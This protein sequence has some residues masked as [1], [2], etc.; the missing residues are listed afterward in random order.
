MRRP[1]NR[2]LKLIILSTTLLLWSSIEGE[3]QDKKWYNRLSEWV[4][5]EGWNFD[6]HLNTSH[7][8]YFFQFGGKGVE[9]LYLSPI[10]HKGW[11][12]KATFITDYAQPSHRNWHLYQELIISGSV[13]KNAGNGAKIY[14]LGIAYGLGPSWRVLNW[15]N[16]TLDLAP[17]ME[18]KLG[19]YYKPANTNNIANG[20]VSIGLDAWTR[21]RYQIP[22]SV[23]PIAISYTLQAPLIQGA[24]LPEYGQS[25]YDFISGENGSKIKLRAGHPLN[26]QGISQRLL[27]DLPLRNITITLGA[28]HTHF[29]Q[30]INHLK[31][32]EGSWSVVAGVSLDIFRLSGNKAIKSLELNSSL[33]NK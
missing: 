32:T 30:D 4:A 25:Y 3:A 12:G 9:D 28:E 11:E 18:L 10:A 2:L 24:F 33:Y 8:K 31:Y 16:L 14:G 27:V 7:T 13:L 6:G 17:L 23:L 15:N 26:T 5:S 29:R 19:G 21:I 22:W 20:K 1:R